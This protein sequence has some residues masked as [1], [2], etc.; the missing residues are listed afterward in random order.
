MNLFNKL[1]PNYKRVNIKLDQQRSYK[2]QVTLIVDSKVSKSKL[3]QFARKHR[4]INGFYLTT[5]R[6]CTQ[7]INGVVSP[8]PNTYAR[9][10]NDLIIDLNKNNIEAYNMEGLHSHGYI[11]TL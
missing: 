2:S 8:V 7:S 6:N 10:V 11:Q 5:G 9:A 4:K 1:L 3:L